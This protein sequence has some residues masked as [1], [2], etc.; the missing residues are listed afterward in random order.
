MKKYTL[1]KWQNPWHTLEFAFPSENMILKV[2]DVMKEE[3]TFVLYL[4][5]AWV[6]WDIY[7][8]YSVKLS[9]T[10]STEKAPSLQES[11]GTENPMSNHILFHSQNF[12]LYD[13]FSIFSRLSFVANHLVWFHY[14]SCWY[15]N[16][17]YLEHQFYTL[18]HLL[19]HCFK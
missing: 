19:C 10:F 17:S 9:N 2:D 13:S 4:N 16:Q 5:G 15:L 1:T 7:L 8:T 18:F 14:F 6:L 11:L 3:N 12:A